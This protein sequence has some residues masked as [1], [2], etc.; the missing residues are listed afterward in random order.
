M[1]PAFIA[2][3]NL[4]L[5]VLVT[6]LNQPVIAQ[7]SGGFAIVGVDVTPMDTE[8]A[9]MLMGAETKHGTFAFV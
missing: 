3:A 1:S 9:L 7:D 8:R 4:I 6:A 5:L 2:R